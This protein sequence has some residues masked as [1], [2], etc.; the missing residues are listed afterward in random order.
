MN[1][2][3]T[4]KQALKKILKNQ[5]YNFTNPLLRSI[6]NN[7]FYSPPHNLQEYLLDRLSEYNITLGKHHVK[8]EIGDN[9]AQ[10]LISF[11]D[12]W[13]LNKNG[14]DIGVFAVHGRKETTKG[15]GIEVVIKGEETIR[16]FIRE[17]KDVETLM[18]QLN[19]SLKE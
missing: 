7:N 16:G 12:I 15:V 2:P 19:K 4:P 9:T 3:K 6:E 18:E 10:A 14:I 17:R 5:S 11:F 8:C 13:E 1:H